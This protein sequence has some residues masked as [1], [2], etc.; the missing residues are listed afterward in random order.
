[1]WKWC[2]GGLKRG[3]DG[4]D[5]AVAAHFGDES[6]AGAEGAVDA[7]ECDLLAGDAGDPVEGGV[8]EDG[9]ELVFVG[10]GGGVVLLD[11]ETAL[12]GGGEH[13]G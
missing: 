6:A 8:G 11:S 13:G 5:I 12:A 3:A 2:E 10:E 4:G 1:M 9:V 7:G